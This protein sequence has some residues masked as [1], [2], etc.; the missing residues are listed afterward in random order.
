MRSFSIESATPDP[1]GMDGELKGS[2]PVQVELP[3]AA[4]RVFA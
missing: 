1:L 2:T 4:L 3:P